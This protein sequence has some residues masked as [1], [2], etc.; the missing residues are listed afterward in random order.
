M[1]ILEVNSSQFEESIP[2]PYFIFGSA[3]FNYLNRSNCE[4]E[5][6]LLFKDGKYRLGII[7]GIRGKQFLS[8]FSAPFGGFTYLTNSIRLQHI[9]KA[10]DLLEEWALGKEIEG[11]HITLPP[12]IYDNTFISKQIN[13]LFRKSYVISKVDLNY[14]FRLSDFGEQYLGKTWR[15][16]RK[17]LNIALS[18]NLAFHLVKT[19]EDKKLAY[20]I[21]RQ[22]REAKG[23][24]LRLTWP[25]V[26]GT[27]TIIPADF[28]IV[29]DENKKPIASSIVFHINPHIVQVVYWGDLPENAALKP[30]NFLSFKVFDYY[31]NL[32]MKI[33]DIGP[34]SESSVPNY[35]LCEFKE[36]IG[37]SISQKYSLVKSL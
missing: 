32:R 25:Q 29:Y 4:K 17:N 11:V 9:E 6:Y 23:F 18:S 24:P 31:K 10:I 15:N 34:S 12:T 16:A 19:L 3:Q 33:V 21:I 30:M 8:P 36:S 14:S 7:G 5:V 20:E 26:E 28:F 13:C 35:G 22:N 27:I 37:C 1:E 2:D